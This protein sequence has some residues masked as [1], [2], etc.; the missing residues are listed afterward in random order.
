[1]HSQLEILSRALSDTMRCD[2]YRL[3]RRLDRLRTRMKA[4]VERDMAELAELAD[5]IRQS[6]E[7]RL[8]RVERLPVPSFPDEL[9][10]SERREE[11]A[12]AIV[13]HPVVVV[14]GET[15]SGKTTQLPKI[16]LSAGRGAAGMIGCTQ[17]RRIAARSI[18]ARIADELKTDVGHAVGYKVRFSDRL[19][20]DTYIKLMTDGILL[21]ETQGDR[22]LNA[23]DTLILDEAHERN[24]NVD[25]LLG[26]FKQLLPKRPDLKLIITS[27]TIDTARFSAHFNDAPIIAVTGR[28]YPVEVRYRP[29][30]EPQENA[31]KEKAEKADKNNRDLQQAIL[32]AVDEISRSKTR[33]DILIFLSG[34]RDIRETAEALRKHRLPDIEILP[35]YARLSAAEQNRV[36]KPGAKQRIVLATNVAETSLTV[37][38]IYAVI[39]PGLAR[40]NRYSA[41]V[42]VQRLQ[43]EKISRSSADQRKGRCGRL[44]PGLC[45][46]LY[47]EEDYNLRAKFTDPEILRSSLAA[48]IL[49]MLHLRLGDVA[50]FPFIDPPA[51]RL[52]NDGFKLLAELGAVDEKRKVTEIGRQL[53]AL[54]IDP[55]IGRM[56]LAAKEENCLKEVLIIAGA[57]SIQDPRERPLDAQQ[58]ADEAQKIFVDERSDFLAFLKLW[59][60][61]SEQTKH[62][63]QNKLR[64]LCVKHF[65][66]YNRMREW[67]DIHQQLHT[68]VR[69][70]GWQP[71]QIPAAYQEIHCALLT[72]LLGNIAM[73]TEKEQYLGARG[74]KPAIFPGSSLFKKGPKW[75]MAAEL[76]ETARLYARCA[77]KIEPEWIERIAGDLCRRSYSEAHWEK[78]AARVA[79]FEQVTL[80]GLSVVVRRKVNY[81]PIDPKTS[82]ELF[83]RAALVAG[84][85]HTK[86]DFYQHNH[87]LI[88]E[89]ETL[90]HKSR[91]PD[92]LADENELYEFYAARIPENIYSGVAF[93]KWRTREERKTPRLLF[94]TRETL[95]RHA[96]AEVTAQ[97]FPDSLSVKGM[98]L[99]LQYHFEP[100]H[101]QD[102]ITV[103]IPV[104]ILNQLAP[105]RFDWLTPGL[106]KEK[107][108]ALMRGLPKSL[109]KNFVPIPDVA[110]TAYEM[111]MPGEVPL[112]E[113]LGNYLH[114]ISGIIIPADAWRMEDLPAHLRMNYR[115]VDE[116]DK[117][118]GMSR[119]LRVLQQQWSEQAHARFQQLPGHPLE[120]DHLKTWDFGDLPA[121]VTLD[122]Q[123]IKLEGFPALVDK[124]EYAD[125]KI[126]DNEKKAQRQHRAGLRR[127]FLLC[128]VP[129]LKKLRRQLPVTHTMCLQYATV[130]RC[131]SLKED[132]LFALADA[133]FLVNPLPV[134]QQAFEQRLKQG[135]LKIAAEAGPQAEVLKEALAGYHEVA[136]QFKGVFPL[137]KLKTIKEIQAHTAR[138][139]YPGF[140]RETPFERMKHLPRYL[141]AV[142]YR[143]ERLDHKPE[144]DARL[145]A[146]I[147]PLWRAY[148]QRGEQQRKAGIQDPRLDEFRWML[149]ELRVSLFAQ[150]LRTPYPVS[151]KRVEKAWSEL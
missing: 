46:R 113:A 95:M 60:F 62:L 45:I 54:P 52:I 129:A 53:A 3:Q 147:A 130:D 104:Q 20:T 145:A 76:A 114:R 80:Y 9:P 137:G 149:E 125:L 138:L 87:T 2:R 100:S 35:L 55:R 71:N 34:E 59:E 141:K 90:E 128:A 96:G 143:L 37:P 4:P 47:S 64:R 115:L 17:P 135:S 132:F 15:G 117:P 121:K 58:A 31:Q 41:R 77:A 94:L 89:I 25:F 78:R 85:Y 116:Q 21:A 98:A 106:L 56:I 39:D 97:A 109:R 61:F 111:L 101:P 63:S 73:K 22:F 57:L 93:E 140:L 103:Q 82:R 27:A 112:T 30:A 108:I 124:H 146:E 67:R 144:M 70:A 5:K 29:Q 1:M 44:G 68:F 51:P 148:L 83:I 49:R 72:G 118:L 12:A 126:F 8:L 91:R 28:T 23:Y 14:A 11:I 66:S 136:K 92:I 6:I 16:C 42:K 26:Y 102:G 79:A 150:T 122:G 65:L 123:S 119:D 43:I 86:A 139:V 99:A 105:S 81:G 133:V 7:R 84:E 131:E 24:L 13:A 74:L 107:L 134:T 75:M 151:V 40:L 127:L 10:V 38:R 36:F 120:R 48:V 142:R 33:G 88:K 19:S 69:E 32:D 50:D 18:A 110:Q